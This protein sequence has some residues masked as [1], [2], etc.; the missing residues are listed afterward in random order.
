MPTRRV[1]RPSRAV[2]G[3]RPSPAP[4]K[5]RTI[6][7]GALRPLRSLLIGIILLVAIWSIFSIREVRVEGNQY[8]TTQAI[9]K[10]ADASF[11]RHPFSRSTLTLNF[12]NLSTELATAD[13]R[14]KE[15][16]IARSW[17][18]AVVIKV[19]ERQPSLGWKS[20][21]QTYVLDPEGVAV[22]Y[23]TDTSL[24]LPVVEDSTNLPIK[25]GDHVVPTRFVRFVADLINTMPKSSGL[26]ITGM[27]VPDT[28][29]ELYVTTSRKFFIKFDTTREASEQIGDLKLVLDTL[30]KQKKTP[31]EY[32]DLRIAGKAY[33]K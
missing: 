2:Y 6:N 31:G 3:K 7:F 25:I 11:E 24:K 8:V 22:A 30:A 29:S 26:Q 1:V 32:I 21:A 5:G 27:R 17:P 10:L 9:Q 19:V 28:T 16:V 13:Q 12:A 4:R 18:S 20:G 23:Q 15:V 33:Y 14:L